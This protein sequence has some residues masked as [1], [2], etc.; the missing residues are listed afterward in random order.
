SNNRLLMDKAQKLYKDDGT[1]YSYKYGKIYLTRDASLPD[2][3]QSAIWTSTK[4]TV[5]SPF[6]TLTVMS[7]LFKISSVK[8]RMCFMLLIIDC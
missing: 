4:A 5:Y 6:S 8:L 3:Y 1:P 2:Q 7:L